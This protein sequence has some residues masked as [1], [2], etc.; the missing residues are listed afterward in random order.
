MQSRKCTF[1]LCILLQGIQFALSVSSYDIDYGYDDDLAQIK[2]IH[3]D[4]ELRS[5]EFMMMREMADDEPEILTNDEKRIRDALVYSMDKR[6]RRTFPEMIPIL[7]S[8]SNKQRL[9][10]A[11]LIASQTSSKSSK[12]MDLTQ[13]C[14]LLNISSQII[15]KI[16]SVIDLWKWCNNNKNATNTLICTDNKTHANYIARGAIVVVQSD[17][18]LF[19]SFSASFLE[20]GLSQSKVASKS[21][22]LF[23]LN[24]TG[25]RYVF[26]IYGIVGMDSQQQI[27]SHII[28]VEFKRFEMRNR[29]G[30]KVCVC[31]LVAD[32]VGEKM[33]REA[34]KDF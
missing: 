19:F 4:P 25:F 22:F 15:T 21:V 1:L 10:L 8:L 32:G 16:A 18:E 29:G 24:R 27:E 2:H 5:I 7:R 26:S 9:A 31:G 20:A 28:F 30:W 34:R 12:S 17:C 3:P 14:I 6:D 33:L 23:L 13:V 11:A